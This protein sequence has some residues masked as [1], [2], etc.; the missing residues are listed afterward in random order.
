MGSDEF[1]GRNPLH[2]IAASADFLTSCV[3]KLRIAF[4]ESDSAL[5]TPGLEDHGGDGERRSSSSSSA[6]I[7]RPLDILEEASDYLRSIKECC[8]HQTLITNNVLD[9]SRIEAGKVEVLSEIFDPAAVATKVMDMVWGK[10][11]S[12]NINASLDLYEGTHIV[13]GDPMRWSQVLINLTSNALKFTGPGSSMS[14]TVRAPE[15]DPDGDGLVLRAS[16]RDT[17]IGMTPQEIARLFERFGQ[18]NKRISRDYGGSGLGLNI[19]RGLV[20]LL[21]G[22]LSVTS[23]KGQ[24]TEM[25]FYVKVASVEPERVRTW[26][27]KSVAEDVEVEVGSDSIGGGGSVEGGSSPSGSSVATTARTPMEDVVL[28]PTTTAAGSEVSSVVAAPTSADL[29]PSYR[30]E[31]VL[32]AEDNAINQ[33]VLI[34][35]LKRLGYPAIV[36]SNGQEAV[37]KFRASKKKKKEEIGCIIMDIEMPVMDGREATRVI[38]QIENE[39]GEA[40]SG[41]V[42]IALSGNARPGL[43]Q[44]AYDTG[45]DDY[46]TKPCSQADLRRM[47]NKWEATVQ[48]RGT[49]S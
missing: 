32:V 15:P 14:V 36:C 45:L 12:K 17:G 27:A 25:S 9:L 46:L 34:T 44:E 30:F 22:D 37:D 10:A 8:K 35:Y 31:R 4:N 1:K 23:T 29:S 6:S 16:V 20:R 18:L 24:G 47:L 11:Q 13:C 7:S 48:K 26:V 43:L 21:G 2:G 19:S 40:G 39:R 49:A 3:G 41:T 42:I 5:S 28:S 33:K 38:R